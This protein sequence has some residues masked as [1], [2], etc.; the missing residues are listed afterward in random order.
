MKSSNKLVLSAIALVVFVVG[1]SIALSYYERRVRVRDSERH[2]AR[3]AELGVPVVRDPAASR[4][5]GREFYAELESLA[6]RMTATH[7]E[8]R[9]WDDSVPADQLRALGP[10]V[11]ELEALSLDPR[12]PGLLEV[13]VQPHVNDEVAPTNV[14]LQLQIL[15]TN[16]ELKRAGA[17][18]ALPHLYAG[19]DLAACVRRPALHWFITSGVCTIK[20]IRILPELLQAGDLDYA[21]LRVE[22]EPR[23]R[24]ASDPAAFE[25]AMGAHALWLHQL[26]GEWNDSPAELLEAI[27]RQVEINQSTCAPDGSSFPH[28]SLSYYNDLLNGAHQNRRRLDLARVAL[29]LRAH[30]QESGDWPAALEELAPFFNGAV[31]VDPCTGLPFDYERAATQVRLHAPGPVAGPHAETDPAAAGLHWAW[32]R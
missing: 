1:A 18:A 4:I 10:Y 2:L 3:L 5:E 8:I 12:F 30:R 24:R 20:A 14:A 21:Q 13:P 7:P 11:A 25:S 29:A 17:A 31:P 16:A 28:A 22:L 9:G 6:R 32:P 27:V 23:L 15:M 26:A 19:L